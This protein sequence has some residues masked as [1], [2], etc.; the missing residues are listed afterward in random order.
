MSDRRIAE[1]AEENRSPP[2]NL[3]AEQAL[4]GTLLVNNEE[5]SYCINVARGV[6]M[7]GPA[8]SVGAGCRPSHCQVMRGG[9]RRNGGRLCP[10]RSDSRHCR[11]NNP[12]AVP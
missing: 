7:D 2:N 8:H 10:D 4:L 9:V 3:E 11:P 5:L 12:A 6:R 1:K